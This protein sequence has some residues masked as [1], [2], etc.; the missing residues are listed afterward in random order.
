M[1]EHGL[2]QSAIQST[3]LAV[4][5][6][7]NLL[8]AQ[9]KS[10][11]QR[12]NAE[13]NYGLTHLTEKTKTMTK[14]EVLKHI[15]SGKFFSCKFVKQ[16]GEVRLLRGRTGVRTFKDKNGECQTIKGV[17][18]KYKPKDMGY[19]VVL[20]IVKKEYR[21]VN[22]ITLIEFNGQP[23]GQFFITENQVI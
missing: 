19:R 18:M 10:H 2:N 1:L 5:C 20:D 7:L 21:M 22:T 14:T 15:D 12:L 13:Q 11:S 8:V 16:N 3:S 17:G 9:L 6:T 23:V 4:L